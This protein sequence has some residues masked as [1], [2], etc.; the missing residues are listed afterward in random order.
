[1]KLY[2]ILSGRVEMKISLDFDED[3]RFLCGAGWIGG[4]VLLVRN[5]MKLECWLV[6]GLRDGDARCTP[7][8]DMKALF[9][10]GEVETLTPDSEICM[11][12]MI[13]N[14]LSYVA[15]QMSGKSANSGG[16]DLMEIDVL[17]GFPENLS[18]GDSLVVLNT[19]QCERQLTG[20]GPF[21]KM[22][23]SPKQDTLATISID[24]E[25]GDFFLR[26]LDSKTKNLLNSTS[27]DSMP[28]DE[29][30]W[31]GPDAVAVY[32]DWET[33]RKDKTSLLLMYDPKMNFTKFQFYGSVHLAPEV[34]GL[35]IIE[36]SKTSFLQK[37]PG[38]LQEIFG[39]GSIGPAEEVYSSYQNF[40]R[41]S[42][43]SLKKIRELPNLAAAVET[44]LKAASF[45]FDTSVQGQLL[46]AASYGKSFAQCKGFSHDKFANTCK[47][48]RVLNAVRKPKIG[49][50]LTFTQFLT[51]TPHGLISHLI[52][53]HHH[54]LALKMCEYLALP[55]EKTRV[56][57]HWA[58]SK[59]L[60]DEPAEEI[61]RS[62]EEKLSSKKDNV[63]FAAIAATAFRNSKRSLAIE[64][65]RNEPMAGEQVPLLLKMNQ[66]DAALTK[67]IE[68][69]ETDLIYLVVLE[70]KQVRDADGLSKVMDNPQFAIAKNLLISYCKEQDIDFLKTM[71]EVLQAFKDAADM[72]V[73]QSF[74]VHDL[75]TK[76]K[77][78]ARAKDLF[79]R[80][81]MSYEDAKA[82][83][84]QRRLIDLQHELNDL[85]GK[86]IFSGFSISDTIYQ[87]IFL[88]SQ[89]PDLLKKAVSIKKEFKVSDKRFWWIKIRALAKSQ[90]W[91]ALERFAQAKK[92]PI[93]YRPFVEVCL[94]NGNEEEAKKYIPL[95]SEAFAKVELYCHPM[96]QNYE[97]AIQTAVAKKD[98]DQ[99]KFI[100]SKCPDDYKQAITHHVQSI[101]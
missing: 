97:A 96:I 10:P 72:F 76:R 35:R 69:G 84:N 16:I 20:M 64:L 63:S 67:A 40:Q 54:Y 50:P 95:V 23:L 32:W 1:M 39:I 3:Q 79:S 90:R 47:T 99:L 43:M 22:A 70:M 66:Q 74:K 2:I 77:L 78:L 34:D 48:L 82:T 17:I 98:V 61:L 9:A 7:L 71:Y 75:P 94:D 13:N 59:V 49:M 33:L 100:Y 85:I 26:I 53:R 88:S 14:G 65:L 73:L 81:K 27:K 86:P 8:A 92:P 41:G 51:L 101:S 19:M 15:N 58:C 57:L 52:A 87:L 56:L 28:P 12:V 42:L 11:Q 24:N 83:D 60:Q 62:I 29:V 89:Y 18:C 36:T 68:S 5:Q 80:D 37:V 55:D 38:P 21:L 30:A 45:E 91:E 4:V 31:V 93:G 44:C 6:S 25:S 46:K